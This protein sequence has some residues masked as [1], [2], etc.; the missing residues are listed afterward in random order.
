M[1][2]MAGVLFGRCRTL[3]QSNLGCAAGLKANLFAKD[4]K[5]QVLAADALKAWV[6]DNPNEVR[7]APHGCPGSGWHEREGQVLP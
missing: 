3:Y 5:K 2:A 7:V 1:S 4:F 6:L